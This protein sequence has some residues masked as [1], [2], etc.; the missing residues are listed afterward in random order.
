[1]GTFFTSKHGLGSRG[2]GGTPRPSQS[3]VPP[4][5]HVTV[6]LVGV[7]TLNLALP[8]PP[9]RQCV[10]AAPPKS[11]TIEKSRKPKLM[12]VKILMTIL[13]ML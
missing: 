1:M 8:P 5:G 7:A 3:R 2:P 12:R 11:F 6:A 10:A 13:I 9:I 4:P